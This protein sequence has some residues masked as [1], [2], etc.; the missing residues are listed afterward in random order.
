MH[1]DGPA[2]AALWAHALVYFPKHFLNLSIGNLPREGEER[3]TLLAAG[4]TK[5]QVTFAFSSKEDAS[6]TVIA[7]GREAT[8]GMPVIPFFVGC[9][10]DQKCSTSLL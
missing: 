3:T 9:A 5:S 4:V 8:P 6:S 1:I 7:V 10:V 2:A